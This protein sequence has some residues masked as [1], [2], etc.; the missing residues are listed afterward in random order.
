MGRRRKQEEKQQGGGRGL[1]GGGV[2]R[3]E[4]FGGGRSLEEGGAGA[5][6][7]PPP[8]LPT[9]ACSQASVVKPTQ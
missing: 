5:L 4:G 8:L 2:W 3:E 1:E 9:R 6:P 7:L